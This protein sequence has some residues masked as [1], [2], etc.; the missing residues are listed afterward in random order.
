MQ[1]A[2]RFLGIVTCL[3]LV[4]AAFAGPVRAAAHELTYSS[5]FPPTHVQSQLAEAWC[6][7]VKE[8][9]GGK[10]NVHFYP[11]QSLTDAAQTFDAVVT[12]RADIG[13]SCLLYNRGRFPL[14][15]FINLPFGNPDGRFATAVINEIYDEFRPE[16]LS[17]VKVLYFHAHG[18]GFIHTVGEPV[19][20][21]EGLKGKKI[22]CPGSVAETVELLGAN[23]VTMPMPEVYQSLKKGVVDGAVYPMETNKGWKMGEVIDSTTACYSVAYSV[24]FF[25]VMNQDTWQGLSQASR[26]SIEAINREWAIK[27]GRAWD[28]SDFEGTRFSLKQGNRMVGLGPERA[29]RWEEAV[30]PAFSRYVEMTKE[31]GLPGQKVL[32]YL[33]QRLRQY[34]QGDFQSRYIAE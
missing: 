7:E 29:E 13:M 30:E 1:S 31:E 9:T 27:H 11:G 26:E 17:Q 16:E 24:G 25:V 5:F 18:P 34:R 10:V 21:L 6:K 33:H 15:D 19:R 14:M 2:L 23:P 4:F 32:D 28:R 3:A 8:R 20:S 22:R 12:G